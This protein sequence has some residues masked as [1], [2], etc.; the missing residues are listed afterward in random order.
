MAA[1]LLLSSR[2]RPSRAWPPLARTRI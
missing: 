1:R 2:P